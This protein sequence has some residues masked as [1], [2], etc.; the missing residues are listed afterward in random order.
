MLAHSSIDVGSPPSP[1]PTSPRSVSIMTTLVDW[2]TIGW[3]RR[4]CESPALLK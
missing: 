2:L 1:M 4:P 3:P